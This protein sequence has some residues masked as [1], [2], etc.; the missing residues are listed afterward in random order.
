MKK[1]TKIVSAKVNWDSYKTII[2]SECELLK[3]ETAQLIDHPNKNQVNKVIKN[4]SHKLYSAA[5]ICS[6]N[7]MNNPITRNEDPNAHLTTLIE[8]SEKAFKMYI[9]GD[10]SMNEWLS[11]K[12]LVVEENKK[13]HLSKISQGWC[14]LIKENDSKK[15]WNAINWKGA[16]GSDDF[17]LQKPS[18]KE[19]SAHFFKQM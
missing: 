16:I 12:S 15:I 11:S 4:V 6:Q 18:S 10:T 1:P 13:S 8:E 5:K 2:E 14:N 3:E 9:S 19:L 7:F 17:L